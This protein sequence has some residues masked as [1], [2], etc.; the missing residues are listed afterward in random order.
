MTRKMENWGNCIT[1]LAKES[2]FTWN[3]PM[4]KENMKASYG[5]NYL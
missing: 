4:I 5:L 3:S 2:I 1:I